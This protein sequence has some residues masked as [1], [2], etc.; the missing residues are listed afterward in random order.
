[1]KAMAVQVE[2]IK[3]IELASQHEAPSR[4]WHTS[5]PLLKAKLTPAELELLEIVKNEDLSRADITVL[6]AHAQSVVSCMEKAF[7]GYPPADVIDAMVVVHKALE[8][9]KPSPP[10]E[11]TREISQEQL[12]SAI[13]SDYRKVIELA[14]TTI[15]TADMNKAAQTS[16]KVLQMH[17]SLLPTLLKTHITRVLRGIDGVVAKE[18][19][20][21]EKTKELVAMMAP[22]KAKLNLLS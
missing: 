13:I 20:K 2:L 10:V 9:M 3:L 8:A 6:D 15:K 22:L 16:R 17:P 14:S 1:M 7:E 5:Q 11:P 4:L 18:N 12:K 19:P 21:T